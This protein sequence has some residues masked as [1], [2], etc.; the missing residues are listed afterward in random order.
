MLSYRASGAPV[1]TPES[2]ATGPWKV[3]GGEARAPTPTSATVRSVGQDQ[4]AQGQ[5]VF[6]AQTF[7]QCWA[8]EPGRDEARTPEGSGPRSSG[9]PHSALDGVDLGVVPAVQLGPPTEV[10]SP[11]RDGRQ[12]SRHRTETVAVTSLLPASIGIDTGAGVPLPRDAA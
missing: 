3:R 2:P 4:E 7:S 9:S 5:A 8:L 11:R 6:S 1:A 10:L 12:T